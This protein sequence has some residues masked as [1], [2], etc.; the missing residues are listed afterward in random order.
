MNNTR[1]SEHPFGNSEGIGL[2]FKQA[3]NRLPSNFFETLLLLAA[4]D[5]GIG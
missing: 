5:D 4:V 1:A 3:T 2:E